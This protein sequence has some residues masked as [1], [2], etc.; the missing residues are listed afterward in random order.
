ME[1]DYIKF[2]IECL[3]VIQNPDVEQ[4]TKE[5]AVKELL[6]KSIDYRSGYGDKTKKALKDIVDISAS[7]QEIFVFIMLYLTYNDV[8]C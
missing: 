8:S 6:K 1:N 3:K 2:L 4:S 7:V 5:K